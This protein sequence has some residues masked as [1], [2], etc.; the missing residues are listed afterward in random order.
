MG[1][2]WARER[3]VLDRGQLKSRDESKFI[4]GFSDVS[5]VSREGEQ[6]RLWTFFFTM[7][8]G[9]LVVVV[10]VVADDLF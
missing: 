6:C 4:L 8:G 5:H 1:E 9:G 7:G 10:V 3:L 2:W